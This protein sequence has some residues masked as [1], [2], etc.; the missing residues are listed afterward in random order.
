MTELKELTYGEKAVGL[1][2]NPGGNA[3][4]HDC[5]TAFAGIIDTM[6]ELRNQT[7]SGEVKRMCSVAITELQTAQMWAVKALTWRD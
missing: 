5:K 1:S 2:F 3:D 4:V 6:N 7:S